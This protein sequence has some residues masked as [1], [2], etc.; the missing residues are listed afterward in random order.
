MKSKKMI[1]VALAM[2]LTAS[3]FALTAFAAPGT[4]SM[5]RS[6]LGQSTLG[7]S[8]GGNATIGFSAGDITY[9][10]GALSSV[11]PGL[12]LDFGTH[13]L[14]A[15]YTLGF[16]G[17]RYIF[18]SLNKA[19]Y[20]VD[21]QSGGTNGYMVSLT[22]SP[23]NRG[24][25]GASL[26]LRSDDQGLTTDGA[27]ANPPILFNGRENVT[28]EADGVSPVRLLEGKRNSQDPD[29][30]ALGLWGTN[31]EGDLNVFPHTMLAGQSWALMTW[32]L[33]IA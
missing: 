19:G 30:Q 2:T 10:P 7:Q 22:L 24:L 6:T 18:P 16:S 8:N 31:M 33:T 12:G 26:T 11:E 23:F 28:L 4:I 25:E 1:L 13:T 3:M 5:G 20:T 32:E 21:N 15:S 27:Y 9:R 17:T 29:H 14:G